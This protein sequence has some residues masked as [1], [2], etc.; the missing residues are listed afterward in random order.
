VATAVKWLLGMF[1]HSQYMPTTF[2]MPVRTYQCVFHWTEIREI[3]HCG[4]L[5][6]SVKKFQIWL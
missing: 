1:A 5:W 6:T 3:W 4:L 2:T